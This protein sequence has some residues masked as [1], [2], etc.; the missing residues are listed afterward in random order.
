MILEAQHSSLGNDFGGLKVNDFEGWEVPKW[1]MRPKWFWKI[2]GLYFEWSNKKW[3][4]E[5]IFGYLLHLK[6]HFPRLGW[7]YVNG[8]IRI[9]PNLLHFGRR[10]GRCRG[11]NGRRWRGR[12]HLQ[13]TNGSRGKTRLVVDVVVYRVGS[14]SRLYKWGHK[15]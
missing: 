9:Y 14:P 15:S 13:F 8:P 10:C 4:W 2:R 5:M 3:F 6:N 1:N 11:C 7:C 12:W